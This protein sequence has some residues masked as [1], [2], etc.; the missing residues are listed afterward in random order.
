[1]SKRLLG[2]N[3]LAFLFLLMALLV[4][5]I[6]HTRHKCGMAEPGNMNTF[7]YNLRA[8]EVITLPATINEISGIIYDKDDHL[9]AVDDEQGA[10]FRIKLQK[11]PT[12]EQ[13]PI[14]KKMT[15]KNWCWLTKPFICSAAPEP[16][17]TF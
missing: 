11:E 3:S 4:T 8:P 10:L 17:F 6:V 12:V 16:L 9:F 2:A 14:G 13:W 7:R 5:V 15:M 1:M